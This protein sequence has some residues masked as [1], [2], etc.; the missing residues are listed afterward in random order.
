M[1]D[2]RPLIP[3]LN[4]Y[5]L[6]A[7]ENS[8]LQHLKDKIASYLYTAVWR[9]GK[10]L[11]I[12]DALSRAPTSHPAPEDDA[13]CADLAA[14]SGL[15][16]L[17]TLLYQRKILCLRMPIGLCRSSEKQR[18]RTLRTSV[19]YDLQSDLLPY[20]KLRDDLSTDG[21]LLLYKARTIV[22]ATLNRHTLSHLH[23]SHRGVEAT[24]RRARQAVFW[25]G[26]NSDI[27]NTVKSCEFC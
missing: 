15:S 23:D 26:I 27:T 9:A 10:Q 12:S 16:S 17:S 21:D 25:P 6:D 11:C 8:C 20:W 4:H 24:K 7:V 5:T 19:S 3:I 2:H 18:G 13:S 22:P 1:T 14:T